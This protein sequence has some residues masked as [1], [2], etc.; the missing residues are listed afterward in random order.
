ME[1]SGEII[2]SLQVRYMT[3]TGNF[4]QKNRARSLDKALTKAL[5]L[6]SCKLSLVDLEPVVND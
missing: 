4:E 3:P 2:K 6:F 1:D 5:L